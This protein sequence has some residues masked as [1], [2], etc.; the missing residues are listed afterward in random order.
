MALNGHRL[1]GLLMGC[2]ALM[3]LAAPAF[4]DD[5][6]QSASSSAQSA[7]ASPPDFLLGRPRVMVGVRGSWFKAS[8]ASDIYDFVT[9]QFTVDKSDFNSGSFT[10]EMSVN[11]ASR[12][13]ITGGIDWNGMKKPSEDRDEEEL[14]PNGS[15]VPIEQVTELEQMNLFGSAKFLLLPRGRRVSSLAWIPNTFVPYVGAGAGYGK[16]TLRQNGD[17]VDFVDHH[18]F[19]DTFRSEGWAPIFH[20]MGGTDIQVMRRLVLSFEARYSWQHADLDT[21]FVD[22][23]PIDLGGFRFGAGVHFAF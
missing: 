20:L 7:P 23:D 17:F 19:T 6:N 10:A 15:R 3:L 13:D 8:A 22:F 9:D 21:D 11:V 18:I 12:V 2:T 14:L 4:A 1:G 5:Q 16:Y